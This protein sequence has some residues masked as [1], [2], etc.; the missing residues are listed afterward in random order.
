VRDNGR[1]LDDFRCAVGGHA[2]FEAKFELGMLV[3]DPSLSRWTVHMQRW[4][5]DVNLRTGMP[6]SDV[7]TG[8][9]GLFS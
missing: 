3:G 1:I 4:L 9:F 5:R 2:I 7:A 6:W 8:Q